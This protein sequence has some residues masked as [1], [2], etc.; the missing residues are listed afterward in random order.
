M[1]YSDTLMQTKEAAGISIIEENMEVT[2]LTKEQ[3]QVFIDKC[4]PVYDFY[5]DEGWFTEDLL[6]RV[7]DQLAD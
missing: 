1:K 5:I 3:K 4:A 2:T 7:R 6:Q